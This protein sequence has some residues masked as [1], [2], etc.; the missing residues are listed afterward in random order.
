MTKLSQ[1]ENSDRGI[2][3]ALQ[4]SIQELVSMFDSLTPERQRKLL[5]NGFD[6]ALKA[7][8]NKHGSGLFENGDFFLDNLK[9][10]LRDRQKANI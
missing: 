10:F 5:N 4:E 8:E 6:A 3:E 1:T 7:V 2:S 9:A